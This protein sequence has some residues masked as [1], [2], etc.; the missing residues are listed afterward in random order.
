MIRA[1][2]ADA[3]TRLAGV[4][5]TPR[6]DAELLLAHL[7]DTDRARLIVLAEESLAPNITAAFAALIA[8]RG[9]G[10][11]VAYLLGRR[12]FWTLTLEV[13]PAVLVPRPDS[14]L[15][16]EIALQ[17]AADRTAPRLLD[18]GTGSGAIGLALAAE[19]PDASV[20]LVDSSAAALEVAESNR[21]RLGLNN[22]QTL[23]GDWFGPVA[24]NRY[25]VIV[26]NPPYLAADDPHLATPEL[27]HEPGDALV[28]GASGLEALA[29]IAAAAP[30]HLLAGGVLALEH[31]SSQ[32]EAVRERLRAAGFRA[33]RTR[34]DLAGLERA[35]Q[36][37]CGD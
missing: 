23:L 22:A 26:A 5:V 10:E 27:R 9:T 14:E 1:A 29:A 11:P 15:L 17:A 28:S 33:V 37:T 8:R 32:G 30:E 19:R 7:L 24:G 16:V 12:D 36:G 2:L 35:T 4:S 3:A 34:R 18:L 21:L 6:L 31:G 20:D 25:D 13:G